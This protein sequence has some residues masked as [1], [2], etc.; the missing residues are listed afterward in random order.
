M[1]NKN[2]LLVA[3]TNQEIKG[4]Y[5]DS[6]IH[7]AYTGNIVPL[8][9]GNH[10][11]DLLVTGPGMVATTF[12]MGQWLAL[13]QY[14]LIINAG[15]A[16]SFN[17]QLQIGQVVNVISDCFPDLGAE[18]DENF[19]PLDRM[20][21]TKPYLPDFVKENHL[22][23]NVS[24]PDIPCVKEL[25]KAKGITVNTISGKKSTIESLK[26]RT[27]ADIETM[28]GAAFFY[29]CHLSQTPC[30]QLRSISNFVEPR[31]LKDW[32]IDEAGKSLCEK[33]IQV[34]DEI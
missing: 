14:D 11:F 23:E 9:Y 19:I 18:A 15:I 29:A 22:I 8:H 2:I 28:E 26:K 7:T 16:G 5:R 31:T 10:M 30:L 34:L 24:F 32:K 3:A 17:P 4:L 20:E 27:N 1:E 25:L 21:M 6:A 33:I 12:Y 13:N